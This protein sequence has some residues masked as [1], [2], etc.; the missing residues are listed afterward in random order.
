MSNKLPWMPLDIPAYRNDTGHLTTLQ[1]GGYMLLLMHYWCQ[2]PLPDDDEQLAAIARMDAKTWRANRKVIRQFFTLHNGELHQ[3]R[4]DTERER[5]AD[6]SA[7]RRGAANQRH[8]PPPNGPANGHAN[9][10]AN[11]PPNG[12]P[13]APPKAGANGPHTVHSTKAQKETVREE[14]RVLINKSSFSEA[15]RARPERPADGLE[16][17]LSAA[18]VTPP[19]PEPMADPSRVVALV[20]GTKRALEMRIPYGET[21]SVEAQL[22]A[23]KAQP[24]AVGSEASMGLLWQPAE[25]KR[26]PA[27]QYAELTGCSLAEAEAKFAA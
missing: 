24:A 25:P 18:G 27:Q 13:D 23:L 5:A 21:R 8:H 11:A 16:A 14:E 1:H 19:E 3:K 12:H 15:P 6:I 9:A 20:R 7:K 22:D 2:G 26:T 4:A 17:L 10:D